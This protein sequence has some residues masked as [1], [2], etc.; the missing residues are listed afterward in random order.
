MG[1]G[2]AEVVVAAVVGAGEGALVE[3]S[4]VVIGRGEGNLLD[5]AGDAWEGGLDGGGEE[6]EKE[7]GGCGELHLALSGLFRGKTMDLG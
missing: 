5:G 6:G 7:G 2:P 1:A 3:G 4:G